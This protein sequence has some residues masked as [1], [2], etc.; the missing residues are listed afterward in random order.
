MAGAGAAVESY[1]RTLAG[2]EVADG[3]VP[4]FAGFV[5]GEGGV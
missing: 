3:F 1:K 5:L 2:L 4:G